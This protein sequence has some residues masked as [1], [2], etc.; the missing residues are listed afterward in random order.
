MNDP[1]DELINHKLV[2]VVPGTEDHFQVLARGLSGVILMQTASRSGTVNTYKRIQSLSKPSVGMKVQDAVTGLGSLTRWELQ[3]ILSQEGWKLVHLKTKKMPPITQSILQDQKIERTYYYDLT[4]GKDYLICL[5]LLDRLFAH[6]LQAFHHYQL[7]NYYGVLIDSLQSNPDTVAQIIP[8]QPLVFYK[9]H[10]TRNHEN[11]QKKGTKRKFDGNKHGGLPYDFEIE[12]SLSAM[13]PPTTRPTAAKS[14]PARGR[15]GRGRRNQKT[16]RQEQ[17]HEDPA[18]AKS[19][20]NPKLD[21]ITLQDESGESLKHEQ[22][23]EPTANAA[24]GSRTSGMSANMLLID[25]DS[26]VIDAPVNNRQSAA[27]VTGTETTA[28]TPGV[29][30]AE[31]LHFDEELPSQSFPRWKT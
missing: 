3:M 18:N 11:I 22:E 15:G 27:A 28:V 30:D 16:S 4:L 5:V 19:D 14:R 12:H 8:N 7:Q 23:Q 29:V 10:K 25:S 17:H 9:E 21:G 1:I 26:D 20:A 2:Q 6:G 31:V 24:S 13:Q